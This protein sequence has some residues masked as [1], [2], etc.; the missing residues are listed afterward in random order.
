MIFLSRI[1]MN[2]LYDVFRH[3]RLSRDKGGGGV[4]D[5][6]SPLQYMLQVD[7]SRQVTV[8]IPLLRE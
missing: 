3:L 8:V 4:V 7:A 1:I 2:P 5:T 6:C